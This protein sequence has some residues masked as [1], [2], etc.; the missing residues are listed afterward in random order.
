M[1]LPIV[2]LLASAGPIQ[3]VADVVPATQQSSITEQ[4]RGAIASDSN[5]FV[6]P[7]PMGFVRRFR[8]KRGSPDN[9]MIV[10]PNPCLAD[11][12]CQAVCAH[13]TAYVFSDGE[14]PKLQ[15]VTVVQIWMLLI[16]RSGRA[17][18]CRRT[19]SNPI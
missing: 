12:T 7:G 8:G 3:Q 2:L 18:I 5:R 11:G 15:Y 14:N 4:N 19:S 9:G 1:L 17:I 13:I 10:T 6:N 16:R